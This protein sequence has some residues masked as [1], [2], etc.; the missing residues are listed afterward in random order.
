MRKFTLASVLAF[1]V[2]GAAVASAAQHPAAE[3]VAAAEIESMLQTHPAVKLAQ[4][5]GIPDPRYVEVPAAFVELVADAMASEAELIAHCK[6]QLA[7]FKIP[8][9]VRFVE[10]WPMSTSK[11]QKYRLRARLIAMCAVD[12]QGSP[13]FDVSDVISLSNKS[14]AAL[15][16]L[17]EVAS[18]LAGL[19]EE[20][21]EELEQGFGTAQSAPSTSA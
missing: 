20:D 17:F 14:A 13:L 12:E 21:V 18:R 19:D 11:I 4:V 6:G 3:N 2:C 1:V 15:E 10:E 8:R 16:R 9:H 7:S 5:V